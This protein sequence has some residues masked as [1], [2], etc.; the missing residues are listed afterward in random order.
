MPEEQPQEDDEIKKEDTE[1]KDAA[2]AG[3]EEK[4]EEEEEVENTKDEDI[5]DVVEEFSGRL[6]HRDVNVEE[7]PGGTPA[8]RSLRVCDVNPWQSGTFLANALP[9]RASTT[10]IP[11]L[12]DRDH[13]VLRQLARLRR[14]L[15]QKRKKNGCTRAQ[16]THGNY[17]CRYGAAVAGEPGDAAGDVGRVQ[18][19]ILCQM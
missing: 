7:L 4:G 2:A 14:N 8:R 19:Y 6:M 9:G 12:H 5:E 10:L 16:S 17:A 13:P 18:E 3:G 15:R 1:M 11:P